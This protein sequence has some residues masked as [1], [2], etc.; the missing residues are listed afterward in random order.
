MF[1]FE[2]PWVFLALPLPLL[3]YYLFPAGVDCL[4]ESPPLAIFD[5]DRLCLTIGCELG[6]AHCILG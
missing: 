4:A 2:W 6:Q 1:Q 5:N 3:V